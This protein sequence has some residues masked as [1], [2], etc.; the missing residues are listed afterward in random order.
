MKSSVEYDNVTVIYNHHHVHVPIINYYY[1]YVQIFLN[2]QIN[3][4]FLFHI[5]MFNTLNIS[6]HSTYISL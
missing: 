4:Q 6:F 2:L 5:K 1:Y 3:I